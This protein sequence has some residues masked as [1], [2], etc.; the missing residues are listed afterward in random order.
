MSLYG[1]RD[2]AMNWQEEVAK[3]MSRWGFKRGKY[4]PCVYW[5]PQTKLMVMVHGDDFMSV[6]T[7][8]AAKA[9]KQKLEGR[10]EIKTQVVGSRGGVPIA[11][12][13]TT[14]PEDLEEVSEARVLNRIVRCR[15]DG[16]EIEADQ[17]HVDIIVRDIGLSEARPASTPGE[18]ETRDDVEL[19]E[20]ELEGSEASRFRALAARANYLAADRPDIM[21]ATKEICRAMAKPTHGAWKKL[22]RL[23]RYLAGSGRTVS[24]YEWQGE[25]SEITGY[26]DSD[27]AGCRVTGKSISGGA[28]MCG[29]HYIKGWARTQ[30]HVTMSSA[31]AEF[32]ALVK[33]SAELLGVR[34]MLKGWEVDASDIIYADSSAAL[35][36]AKRKGAGKLRHINVASLWIQE[37]QDTKELE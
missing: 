28:L 33:C 12:R 5:H 19:N 29:G 35:A 30:N 22:K 16:W 2:A 32:I 6:G 21:Y 11:S 26:S 8:A 25:E 3:E 27:W 36:I 1:T 9:F 18:P 14:T 10:F 23:G 17:R 24:K 37:R 4:N 20:M 34:S 7:R 13:G 31:E 15:P